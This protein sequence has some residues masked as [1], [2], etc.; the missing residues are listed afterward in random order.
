MKLSIAAKNA[1]IIKT[2]TTFQKI[3]SK[4]KQMIVKTKISFKEYVKLIYSIAY[5][6][7]LLRLLLLVAFLILLWIIFYYLHIFNLPK[8]IIYQ[9]ITLILIVIVQPSLIFVTIWRNY[10]SSNHLQEALEMEISQKEIKITGKSYYMEVKL[11]NLFKIVEKAKWFLMYQNNLSA[12]IVSKKDMNSSDLKT[13]RKIITEI[14]NVP[15]E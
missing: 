14:D 11:E 4:I 6:K 2:V 8:P 10:Y 7:T 12:I 13:I 3:S 1:E 5:K 9:Y 15:V